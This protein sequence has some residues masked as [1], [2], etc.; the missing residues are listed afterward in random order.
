[1]DNENENINSSNDETTEEVA[2]TSEDTTLEAIDTAEEVDVE[3]LQAQ[4]K[5]L[6]ERAKKAEAETKKLKQMGVKKE[7]E[8]SKSSLS[9]QDSI[10]IRDLTEEDANF[11]YEESKIRNKSIAEL[12][13]DPYYKAIL[14]VR[15]EER[16]SAEATHSGKSRS[17][18]SKLTS[19]QIVE[20]SRSGRQMDGADV[21]RA[22]FDLLRNKK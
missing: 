17:G 7:E 11:L 3:A 15:A 5:K 20:M 8:P 12:K 21:A 18:T 2:N 13:K 16:K 10:A 19:E 14:Q 1:M 4:N 9:I 6:F 22:E